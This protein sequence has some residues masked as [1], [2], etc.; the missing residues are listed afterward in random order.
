MT[1]FTIRYASAEDSAAIGRIHAA[2][3]KEAYK[4]L[5]PQRILDGLNA[6][7]SAEKFYRA[8][9]IK[10]ER[11]AVITKDGETAGFICFGKCRDA[12]LDQ[13]CGEIRAIYLRPDYWRTGLGTRL[14]SFGIKELRKNGFDKMVLWVLKENKNACA[15]YEKMGFQRDGAERELDIGG[16]VAECR[17]SIQGKLYILNQ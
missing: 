10:G 16:P 9:A 11:F 4:G 5:I 1:D 8:I 12:D 17:Y 15:F 13:S 14:I 2:S 3:W 6:D 7:K